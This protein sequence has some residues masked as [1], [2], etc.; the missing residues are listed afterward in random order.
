MSVGLP[1]LL[2]TIS[3]PLAWYI[4]YG[5]FLLYN[6]LTGMLGTYLR[7]WR[8]FEGLHCRFATKQT[9]NRNGSTY[10]FRGFFQF[11]FPLEVFFPPSFLSSFFWFLRRERL[12][13]DRCSEYRRS[14]FCFCCCCF[15]LYSLYL[16]LQAGR[17]RIRV[18]FLSSAS[19]R[20]NSMRKVGSIVAKTNSFYLNKRA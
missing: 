12:Q 9:T 19:I 6:S 14:I 13:L 7:Y 1:S 10:Y 3:P 4:L 16:Y 18:I 20:K 5:L 15:F 8:S 11:H 2:R 17:K